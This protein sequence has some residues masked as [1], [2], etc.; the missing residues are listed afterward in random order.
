MLKFSDI[1][2][3]VVHCTDSYRDT[4]TFEQVNF[5]HK[6]NGWK[7]QRSGVNIGYHFFIDGKGR[8]HQGRRIYEDEKALEMGA[9]QYGLNQY[10]IGICLALKKGEEP[11]KAQL[12]NLKTLLRKL[13]EQ[14]NIP[15]ELKNDKGKILKGIIGHRDISKILNNPKMATE[16]PTNALYNALQ[17]IKVELSH[18]VKK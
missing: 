9:A 5:W 7:A 15:S 11:S 2:F 17:I 4:T 14:F 13:M 16:C 3:L 18:E 6:N 1:N 8:I 10:S 12:S